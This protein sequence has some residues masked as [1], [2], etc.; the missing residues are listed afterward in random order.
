MRT[1][2]F[3]DADNFRID[4]KASYPRAAYNKLIKRGFDIGN[5]FLPY[6][7]DGFASNYSW[8]TLQDTKT[9]W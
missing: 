8:E 7:K 9:G 1:F 5:T 3:L 4:V 6:D 2:A